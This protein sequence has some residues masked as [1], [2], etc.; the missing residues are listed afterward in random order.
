MLTAS[1]MLEMIRNGQ[2]TAVQLVQA[3]LD[4]IDQNEASLK[5]W[6]WIDREGALAQAAALD[7]HHRNGRPLAALH[8]IPVGLKDIV[9]TADM[10]TECG[11]IAL[12]GRQPDRDAALVSSLRDAGAVIIG[13]TVTTAF[14]FMQPSVT[15]NPHNYDYSPGGS[16]AGSA[17]AVAAGHLPLAVG[18][19]TNGSVIRPASFCGTVGLKPTEGMISRAGVLQTSQTLD[20]MGAFANSLEDV[21]LICDVMAKN[22]RPAGATPGQGRQQLHAAS[23]QT[24]AIAPKFVQV[25]MPYSDQLADDARSA[26]HKL[27]ARLGV[28]VAVIDARTTLEDIVAVHN[29]IHH[30]EI[31]R[32]LADIRESHPHSFNDKVAKTLADGARISDQRYAAALAMR[33]QAIQIIDRW[34]DDYDVI[35]APSAAGEAPPFDD[36]HTGNPIFSTVWT[37]YGGPCL[38]LPLLASAK[39]LPLGVQLIGRRGSDAD[40]LK[41][42]RWILEV[43]GSGRQEK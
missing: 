28:D 14:A 12:A 16:S 3:A 34:F 31:A 1:Q 32:E 7:L 5:A 2:V 42:G 33:Q 21:A 11:S 39:G 27:T 22:D 29:T 40:L 10:P 18:S 9:D 24:P 26:F 19:Q 6:V 30:Y 43:T 36:G 25:E 37:L 38:T 13:K 4:A 35:L 23:R 17:A 15:R 41:A 8:G 20:Q